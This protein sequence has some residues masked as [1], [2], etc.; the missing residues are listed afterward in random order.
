MSTSEVVR[1]FAVWGIIGATLFS[2]FVIFVFRTGVVYKARN[3]DGSLKEKIPITGYLTSIGFLFLIVFFLVAAYYFGLIQNGYQLS[4]WSLYALNLGLYLILFLF[5]TI[6]ID[7]FVIGYWRPVFLQLPEA[8][9]A[10]SMREHIK[11][12]IPV[13]TVFGLIVSLVC[14]AVSYYIL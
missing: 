10:Q 2:V 13:G 14:T 5:D 1:Y 6:V 11:K 3:E 9:G 4:F 12:S 8:M 7:G